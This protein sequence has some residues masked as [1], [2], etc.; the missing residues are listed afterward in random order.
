MDID[1]ILRVSSNTLD[2]LITSHLVKP[3]LALRQLGFLPL[4]GGNTGTLFTNFLYSMLASGL[5]I[6]S[7]VL[8]SHSSFL[9]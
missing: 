7:S 6:A 3:I 2:L 4:R 9:G 5:N 1:T 8:L